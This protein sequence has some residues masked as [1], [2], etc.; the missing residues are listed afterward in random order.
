MGVKSRD[1]RSTA[2]TSRRGDADTLGPATGRQLQGVGWRCGLCS[3]KA[4][5]SLATRLVYST[6]SR[7]VCLSER[8]LRCSA[9][10][11]SAATSRAGAAIRT[12]TR[13]PRWPSARRSTSRTQSTRARSSAAAGGHKQG[14]E[15][16]QRVRAVFVARVALVVAAALIVH[17][18]GPAPQPSLRPSA[19]PGPTPR[20]AFASGAHRTSPRLALPRG[21][22]SPSWSPVA[23]PA[24]LGG[25]GRGTAASCPAAAG[26]ARWAP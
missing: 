15:A 10:Q 26:P 12:W 2:P 5:Q 4:V 17:F 8:L 6:R 21:L 19:P 7:M 22:R 1:Q 11:C 24:G 18:A 14:E 20:D 23:G 25:C 16:Q 9:A 3:S 13:R